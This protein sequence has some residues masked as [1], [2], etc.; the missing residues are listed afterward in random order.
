MYVDTH[1][2]IYIYIGKHT[3]VISFNFT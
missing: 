1:I 3:Y 2:Y